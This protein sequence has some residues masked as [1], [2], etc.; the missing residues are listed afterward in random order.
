MLGPKLKELLS[1]FERIKLIETDK[2]S[3]PEQIS[4]LSTLE[5]RLSTNIRL[6][7]RSILR[8]ILADSQVMSSTNFKLTNRAFSFTLAS[9]AILILVFIVNAF[10]LIRNVLPPLGELINKTRR[11]MDGDLNQNL[12]PGQEGSIIREHDEI[13]ELATVFD[14]MTKQLVGSL[15]DLENEAK[16]RNLS[17]VKFRGIYE[18]SPIAIE[19]FNKNGKLADV[20]QKTLDLFGVEDKKLCSWI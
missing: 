13:G 18:Q 9:L 6:A 8:Q 14:N 12:K 7:A 15:S 19:I 17:E 2:T 5:S 1:W 20:N 11:I 16:E 3:F 4:T 10:F